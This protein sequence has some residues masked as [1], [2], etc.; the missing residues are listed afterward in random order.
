LCGAQPVAVVDAVTA[1]RD[2]C[3]HNQS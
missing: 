3:L 2:A 1:L